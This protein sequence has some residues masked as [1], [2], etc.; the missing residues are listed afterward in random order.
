MRV[1]LGAGIVAAL[2]VVGVALVLIGPVSIGGAT[3][4]LL[5]LYQPRGLLGSGSFVWKGLYAG[6]ARLKALL[7]G[8]RSY[9]S[10]P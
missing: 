8:G 7:T 6:L 3:L 9:A 1:A 5:M 2:V 10:N 4:V